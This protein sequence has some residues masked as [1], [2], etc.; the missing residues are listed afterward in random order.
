MSFRRTRL[1]C[2]HLLI[3]LA[4]AA[5]P[6][7]S[8]AQSS[9][10]SKPAKKSSSGKTSPLDSGSVSN[11]VYRNPGF[12]FSCKIPPGWVLRTEEMN[13]GAS[14]EGRVGAGTVLLAAFSRPP[15]AR[16]EDVNSSIV[17]AAESVSS[18]PG[19]KE[20]VQYLGVLE[21]FPKSQGFTA[22]AEPEE[23]AID[24]KTLVREDFHKDVG[25]RVM[26]QAM[27]AMLARGYAVSFTFIGGTEDEVEE[28]IDG[29]SFSGGAKTG[30]R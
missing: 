30:V 20:P 23:I 2:I 12:G 7:H 18:Y 25:S 17:I 29:L 24:A 11:G 5:L 15:L 28:L 1:T 14:G 26:Q 22:D 6:A 13:E 27:L 19:L 21:E 9:S 10:S 16:G 8:P 4:M 3:V